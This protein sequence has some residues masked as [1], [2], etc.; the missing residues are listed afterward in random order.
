MIPHSIEADVQG[1]VE[2]AGRPS[3]SYGPGDL[4][5]LVGMVFQDPSSQFTMLTTED[6]V[7]FGLENLGLPACEMPERV[8]A[9]L[10]SVGLGSRAAWR[11]DR[12]SGGQQQRL[13]L[14]ALLAMRPSA[15]ALDEPTA[16][17]D[18]RGATQLYRHVG[19]LARASDLALVVVEHDLDRVVPDLVQ[20]CVL[21]D[22]AGR[23][24]ADGTVAE[25]FG[26]GR[27]VARLLEL[28]VWLP[29]SVALALALG[30]TGATLPVGEAAAAEWLM[31]HP[32][33]QR[34]LRSAAASA[35]ERPVRGQVT[36]E[37]ADLW[38]RY[39]GFVSQHQGLRGVSLHVREG[40]LL[41]IVGPNGSGKSTLLRALSALL[42]LERG[43]VT[44]GGLDLHAASPR[45]AAKLV[46]H[47]FQNPEA[48]FVADTVEEEVAYGPRALGWSD[49]EVHEHVRALLQRFGLGPLARAN[50]FT[51]SQ[52]QKRR[53]SV[54]TALVLG[55]RVL[56]LDEPTFGQDRRSALALVDEIASLRHRG[57]AIVIATHDLGL[58]AEVADRVLALADGSVVYEGPP[59]ALVADAALLQAIGQERPP[60]TRLLAAARCLGADVPSGLRWRDLAHGGART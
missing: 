52:G 18:P 42:P 37:A 4:A 26:D 41:A 6:E 57:M 3:A 40:E 11:I 27:M 45:V 60:L 51:L 5:E 31:G 1:A 44:V 47:V 55:P 39:G 14:A 24:V 49:P 53:L 16:H 9:A 17:L 22:E 33:A 54:A 50:P 25:L 20:R 15:L 43:S 8:R 35:V 46:S 13:V 21:L 59:E 23:M 48:G 10:E 30:E 12:L 19:D 58:V 29:S 2:V 32:E 36:L 34:R 56:L 38:Q 7:A 28:G